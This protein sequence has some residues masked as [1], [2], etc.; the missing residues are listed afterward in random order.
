MPGDGSNGLEEPQSLHR[1]RRTESYSF[2][3][4]IDATDDLE[5]GRPLTERV[6]GIRPAGRASSGSIYSP[7]GIL[8]DFADSFVS[9]F[10]GATDDIPSR[11]TVPI[12]LLALGRRRVLPVWISS[13]SVTETLHNAALMPI[14]AEVSARLPGHPAA[15]AAGPVTYPD[16][17]LAVAGLQAQ[18]AR[19]RHPRASPTSPPSSV[20]LRTMFD[21]TSRYYGVPTAHRHR[22]PRAHRRRSCSSPDAPKLQ[23]RGEH[24]RRQGQRLDHL[25]G[26]YFGDPHGYWKIAEL[27][28]VMHPE[29]LSEARAIPIPIGTWTWHS[30]ASS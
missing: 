17:V 24:L 13:M 18:R 22:P 27:A 20:D 26:F 11:Q 4:E 1:S 15:R 25:A 16:I 28:D 9:L 12:V 21:R 19:A 10:N 8:G 2:K 7:K 6:G 29:A 14:H 3:L 30:I 5:K 23:L